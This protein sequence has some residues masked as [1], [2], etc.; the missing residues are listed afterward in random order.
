MEKKVAVSTYCVWTSYGSI[1]QSYALKRALASLGADSYVFIDEPA[2]DPYQLTGLN[3]RNGL[4]TLITSGYL[5]FNR[6]KI[7]SRYKKTNEFLKNNLDIAEYSDY[8]DLLRNIPSADFYLSGSDQVFNPLKNSPALF[9]DFV[10]DKTRCYTYACSMGETRVPSENEEVFSR[11]INHFRIISCR[12][13]DNIPILQKYNPNAKYFD[14]IDPTFLLTPQE[15]ERIMTP[16]EGAPKKYIL[17]FPIYWDLELNKKLRILH[18]TTGIDIVTICSSFSRV[19]ANKRL[20]DVSVTEFLWLINHAEGVVTSSFHGTA[21]SLILKKKL[22]AVV[23][24]N[25]PSRISCLLD[26]LNAKTLD[27]ENLISSDLNYDIVNHNIQKEKA[28]SMAYLEEI[29]GE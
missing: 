21:L 23:N 12:E 17:V 4:K 27:I 3:G 8:Q 13:E 28:K 22:A 9:L 26:K 25:L 15:W 24:P 1:L 20:F 29:F 7:L 19:Y 2:A 16:Y 6:N 11:F 14:H 18:E 10:K 5:R